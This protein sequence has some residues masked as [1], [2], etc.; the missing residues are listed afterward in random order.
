[1]ASIRKI[2]GKGGDSYK[3]TVTTGRDATGKQVRHYKTWKPESGMTARQIN[4]ELHRIAYEFERS[5]EFGYRADDH[6]T[7]AQF[8]EYCVMLKEQRGDK[9]K[10]I[11]F[12][13]RLYKRLCEYIG[14]MKL[15]DIRP[16]HINAIYRDMMRSGSSRRGDRARLVVDFGEVIPPGETFESFA[17]KCGISRK[18]LQKIHAGS[19]CMPYIADKISKASGRKDLFRIIENTDA[20]GANTINIYHACLVATF[21][22][23]V[24][25]M[26]LEY[27]P[28][29]K[30]NPPKRERAERRSLQPDEIARL[31]QCIEEEN[32]RTRTIV[33]LLAVTGCRRGELLALKWENIDL[34][35]GQ[36]NICASLNYSP[37]IGV[38][39]GDTKT[40]THRV[41][42]VSD[43]VVSLLKKYRVWQT[44]ERLK[45]CDMWQGS[46]YVFTNQY[47]GTLYPDAINSI[48]ARLCKKYNLPHIHPHTFRHTAASIM[49]THGVDVLTVAKMLGHANTT[50][51][52]N[53]YAHEIYEAK[54]AAAECV[55]DAVLGCKPK[56]A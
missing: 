14:A 16:Q 23:A 50:T 28:A 48:L 2:E 41:V 35:S 37:S 17:R 27:N 42:P 43:S 3:I 53:T 56:M 7:F 6:Q 33:T 39:E 5:I 21:T 10:S 54:E 15:S 22:Q 26:I 13:R 31:M 11:E 40:S 46:G 32:I 29:Q 25:E 24:N 18:T 49:L 20:I 30:A 45:L 8:A 44:A 52:L 51:T 38:F 34:R 47:G 19:D 36:I 1:M 55:S 12:S 9:P 4:K